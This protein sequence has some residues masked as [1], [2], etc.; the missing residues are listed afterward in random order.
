MIDNPKYIELLE[1]LKEY[2]EVTEKVHVGLNENSLPRIVSIDVKHG[3]YACDSELT[4]DYWIITCNDNSTEPTVISQDHIF[5]KAC[6][7]VINI[8]KKSINKARGHL[9]FLH[10]DT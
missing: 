6:E 1:T 5:E 10:G 4:L 2:Q 3:F 9:K 7:N 8:M